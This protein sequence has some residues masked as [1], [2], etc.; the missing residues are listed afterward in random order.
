MFHELGKADLYALIV[1]VECAVY[2]V[3][4]RHLL[5]CVCELNFL[6]LCIENIAI[7]SLFLS[8]DVLSEIEGSSLGIAV[9]VCYKGRYDI[10]V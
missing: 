2:C 4:D 10:A 3:C 1:V 8:Y 6:C 9:F 7:G 5:S